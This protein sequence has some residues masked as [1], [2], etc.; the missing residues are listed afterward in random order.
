MGPG[1]RVV[2]GDGNAGK[3]PQLRRVM[4]ARRKRAGR[5]GKWWRRPKALARWRPPLQF[6]KGGGT[7]AH[8][9]AQ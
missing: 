7:G 6:G 2:M 5:A 9:V 8:R 1:A 4:V 3:T